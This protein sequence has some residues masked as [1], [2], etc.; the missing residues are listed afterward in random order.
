MSL[1]I[2]IIGSGV[3]GL[4]S[5]AVLRHSAEVKII[6]RGNTARIAGGQGISL[7][8][9]AVKILDSIGWDREKV[10]A[11]VSMGLKAYDARSGKL[12]KTIRT[13][14]PQKWGAD[15][16]VQLRADFRNELV[17][18]ATEDGPGKTPTVLYET[19]VADIDTESGTV[20]LEDGQQI[21]SDVIIGESSVILF[22]FFLP[23][24][25]EA[26]DTDTTY[27]VAAGIHTSFRDKI[28][29][30][31]DIRPVPTG[32]SIF[33]FLV[34]AEN[35]AK[36]VGHLHEWWDPAVGGY[37]SIMRSDDGTN[38]AIIAYPSQNFQY[39]NFSCAF[40]NTYLKT[41]AGESWFEEGDL[42]EVLEIFKDFPSEY[43]AFIQ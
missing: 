31:Q 6:E 20:T 37:L 38:R 18:L 3:A 11:V 26:G 43:K 24:V 2:I 5:A 39:V 21:S 35:A 13:D 33:R 17:R 15:W 22:F 12:V 27:A 30:T 34:S 28:L 36:A 23:V 7:G 29:G 25:Q 40:P 41:G 4:A 14:D 8:P 9:N 19:K 42:S 16:T 1:S 10:Q 32:Q